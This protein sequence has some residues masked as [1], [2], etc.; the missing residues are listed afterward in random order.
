MTCRLDASVFEVAEPTFPYEER[1]WGRYNHSMQRKIVECLKQEGEPDIASQ[2]CLDNEANEQLVTYSINTGL[3]LDVRPCNLKD[4]V[5][6]FRQSHPIWS[7]SQEDHV[8]LYFKTYQHMEL[9]VDRMSYALT[10]NLSKAARKYL[11][12]LQDNVLGR[13]YCLVNISDL[14][15]YVGDAYR[16][17]KLELTRFNFLRNVK[18]RLPKQLS[19]VQVNPLLMYRGMPLSQKSS[20]VDDWYKSIK[21]RVKGGY[22][23]SDSIDECLKDF[24]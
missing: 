9:T 15:A 24:R 4:E 14:T 3:V 7:L 8:R 10:E 11:T 13:N 19:L 22:S 23:L 16:K 12:Y 5:V 20:P 21:P 2:V 6:N 18:T 1:S 17:A